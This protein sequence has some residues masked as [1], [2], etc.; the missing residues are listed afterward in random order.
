MK[1]KVATARALAAYTAARS[2]RLITLAFSIITI[3]LLLVAFLLTYYISAWWLLL[4]IP[5][6]F[7][8][9]VFLIIRF[10]VN[11]IVRLIYR[12]PFNHDQRKKLEAFTQKIIGLLEARSTPPFFFAIMTVKDILIRRDA[13]TL[14]SLI[15]D[16]ISLKS[17]FA[18]LEKHF[19]ER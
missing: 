7:F 10:I 18:D 19:G 5:I 15:S 1:P 12:H 9:L 11:R 13:T 8:G 3:I 16:S 14:R 4:L 17:N 6:L 2:I